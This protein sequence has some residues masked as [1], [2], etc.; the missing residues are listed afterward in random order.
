MIFLLID[1]IRFHSNGK[2]PRHGAAFHGTPLIDF[3]L[4]FDRN[5]NIDARA[6]DRFLPG[7]F[8]IGA[9]KDIHGDFHGEDA[10]HILVTENECHG[11]FSPV[12]LKRALP[13][14]AINLVSTKVGMLYSSNDAVQIARD[15][16]K[17]S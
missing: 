1:H 11:K 6:A 17:G 13:L 10:L 9:L 8:D 7:Q 5:L 15:C 16:V 4:V 2:I 3:F 14:R 12:S